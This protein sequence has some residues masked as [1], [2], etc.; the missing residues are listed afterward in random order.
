MSE[1]LL[2]FVANLSD[3]VEIG[4]FHESGVADQ[5]KL[6]VALKSLFLE[7]I[8]VDIAIFGN[9]VADKMIDVGA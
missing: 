8:V 6:G 1:F 3:A 9:T 2:G 4:D 7:V 5:N